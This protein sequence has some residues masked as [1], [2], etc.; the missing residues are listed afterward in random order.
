V[1]KII[2]VVFVGGAVGAMLREFLML[3]VPSL[4][5]G[6]PLDI[7]AANLVASFLLGFATALHGRKVL[8]DSVN[9]LMGTGIAGGL[10]TFS[11]F[12]YGVAML[13]TASAT[14]AVVPFAYVVVSLVL[15][16][17]AV[18]AGLMLGRQRSN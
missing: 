16:Y 15:G 11:S 13:A 9:S 6:F 5:D 10:S 8:S 18:A 2:A 4:A 12:A 14:S 3:I 1:I 7:L 17:V